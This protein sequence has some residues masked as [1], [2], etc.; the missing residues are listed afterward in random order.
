MAMCHQF[1]DASRGQ[2]DAVF[3]VLDFFGDADKHGLFYQIGLVS[4]QAV[5]AMAC[6]NAWAIRSI[7]SFSTTSGGDRAMTSPLQRTISSKSWNQRVKTSRSEERRVGKGC[8]RKG[9][10]RGDP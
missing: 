2:A 8:V 5:F 6:A 3:M 10:S 1:T 9:R 4:D 7:C